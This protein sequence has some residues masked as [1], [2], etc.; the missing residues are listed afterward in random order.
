MK[1]SEDQFLEWAELDRERSQHTLTRYR[2][3]LDSLRAF[4][5]PAT[6][7]VEQVE[8]WWKS[9]YGA[10]SGTRANELAC[11]KAFYKYCAAF[12]IRIEDPTRRL[13]APKVQV[14][15]PRMIGRT[16]FENLLGKLSA[17][18]L[19]LRRAYALGGYAGLRI[20]EAATLDW[21]DIDQEAR[22]MY[23]TGKG[24]KERPVPLSPVLLDYL[25]PNTG[26]NVITAG[27]KP[28]SAAVLQ[29]KINRHMATHGID[30]TFHDLRKRGA[31]IALSSGASPIA[32][33]T[34][35]GWASMQTVAHYA[36]VGD[37]ELDRIAEMLT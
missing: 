32:V 21:R 16:D 27:G 10:A 7:T 14:K 11:L 22:R 12:D 5:D 3:T 36:V 15:V 4:A 8:E 23:V 35:F 20:S 28:P 17:N 13:F 6:A 33:K 34:M 24:S 31:S 26:G 2:A 30:H 37:N 9:R 25:L 19:V 18:D 1:T 29:R